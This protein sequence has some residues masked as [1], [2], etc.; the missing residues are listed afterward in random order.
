MRRIPDILISHTVLGVVCVLVLSWLYFLFSLGFPI[1]D[2]GAAGVFLCMGEVSLFPLN[3]AVWLAPAL[4]LFV[5]SV[6]INI[7]VNDDS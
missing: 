6:V 7:V 1:K 4:F 3:K 5:A 2:L